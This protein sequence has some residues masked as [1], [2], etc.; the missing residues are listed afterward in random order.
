MNERATAPV[1]LSQTASNSSHNSLTVFVFIAKVI[2][3]DEQIPVRWQ[4]GFGEVLYTSQGGSWFF[5][6]RAKKSAPEV[7]PTTTK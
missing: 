7:L 3:S 5:H 2:A 1:R 6:R 4:C